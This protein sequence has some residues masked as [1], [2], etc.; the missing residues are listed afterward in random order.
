MQDVLE[1]ANH[2]RSVIL[3]F[4][5]ENAAARSLGSWQLWLFWLLHPQPSNSCSILALLP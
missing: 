3:K 2:T 1:R 4:C 5:V